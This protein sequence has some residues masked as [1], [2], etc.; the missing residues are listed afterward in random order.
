MP[1]QPAGSLLAHFNAAKRMFRKVNTYP[2]E[3]G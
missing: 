2:T 3:L 1:I